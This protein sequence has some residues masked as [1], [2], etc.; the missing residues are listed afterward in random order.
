VYKAPNGTTFQDGGLKNNNPISLAVEEARLAWPSSPNIDIAVSVG[1]GCSAKQA[2]KGGWMFWPSWLKRCVDSF[3]SNLD[4]ERLWQ[5][6]ASKLDT[7]KKERHHRLNVEFSTPLPSLDAAAEIA[8]LDNVT[9][10]YFE[11]EKARS[12]LQRTA[13]GLLA[14]LFYLNVQKAI[15]DP[16]GVYFVVGRV[17]C[18]LE[19]KHQLALMARLR[20]SG[21]FFHVKGV[22]HEINFSTQETA[23]QAG[24]AFELPIHYTISEL[25]E[26]VSV[27]LAFSATDA[28]VP[29]N[30][31][32][33]PQRKYHIGG[34]PVAQCVTGFE[35]RA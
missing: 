10:E 11:N 6:Y 34:S 15:R 17:L 35:K 25:S 8:D 14:S 19:Q 12:Q 33:V 20:L 18:R 2:A 21:C 24:T 5:E 29:G 9:I 30:S 13:E 1:T 26:M 31:L 7:D 32:V 22:I 16:T 3:E 27:C 23:M 28:G 4:S